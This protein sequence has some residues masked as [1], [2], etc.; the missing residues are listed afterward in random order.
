[1][2][3]EIP[4]GEA[5]NITTAG[6][7][8]ATD[9]VSLES[10]FDTDQPVYIALAESAPASADDYD[11]QIVPDRLSQLNFRTVQGVSGQSIFAFRPSTNGQ[12]SV[13]LRVSS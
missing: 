9:L 2:L 7:F 4:N 13:F 6:S 1:M 8:N 3:I 11:A 10:N 5:V 12:D